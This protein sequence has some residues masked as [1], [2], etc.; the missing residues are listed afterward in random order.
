MLGKCKVAGAAPP[1]AAGSTPP[2]A[3]Q[4]LRLRAPPT[5]PPRAGQAAALS[6]MHCALRQTPPCCITGR[7]S[8]LDPISPAHEEEEV[9]KT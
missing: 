7:R 3:A 1:G 2:R 6:L 8:L 4:V 5:A 9:K